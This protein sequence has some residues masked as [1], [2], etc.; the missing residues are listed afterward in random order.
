MSVLELLLRELQEHCSNEE[1]T[2]T[3]P[4]NYIR[5]VLKDQCKQ[6]WTAWIGD[7]NVDL[8]RWKWLHCL[9]KT[10]GEHGMSSKESSLENGIENVLQV[11]QMYWQRNIDHELDIIDHECIIDSESFSTQGL[12]PLPRK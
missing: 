12:K 5:D 2:I 3:Q 8:S 9:L 7:A 10:L 4:D 6:L 11:K 1:W